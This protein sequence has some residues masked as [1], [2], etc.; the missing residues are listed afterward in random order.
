MRLTFLILSFLFCACAT[1]VY[2][3]TDQNLSLMDIKKAVTSV[4]GDPRALSENQRTY[5]S[6]YFGRKSDSRFDAAKSRE[7]LYSKVVIL[8]DRR[9]YDVEVE[10]FVEEKEGKDYVP[11]GNDKAEAKKL[12]KELRSRLNQS[13]EDRNVIDDFRAF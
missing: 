3:I 4:I 2:K 12:G 5:I 8:G 6:Q 13:R 7:R 9:P 11:V 10:V 1:R